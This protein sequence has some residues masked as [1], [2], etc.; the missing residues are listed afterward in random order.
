MLLTD[1]QYAPLIKTIRPGETPA[2]R[3]TINPRVAGVP[4]D[5]MNALFDDANRRFMYSMFGRKWERRKSPLTVL[6]PE[7]ESRRTTGNQPQLLHYHGCVWTGN[8][9]VLFRYVAGGFSTI[10]CNMIR[11]RFKT[12]SLPSVLVQDFDPEMSWMGYATKNYGWD[13]NDEDT[14]VFGHNRKGSQ[15]HPIT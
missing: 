14:Y 9:R 7:L 11:S 3:L 10:V 8:R 15:R 13:F 5:A 6:C 2:F 1:S 4:V 12:Q